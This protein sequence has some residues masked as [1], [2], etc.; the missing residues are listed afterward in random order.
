MFSKI[1]SLSQTSINK[2]N[3]LFPQIVISIL[4]ASKLKNQTEFSLE[5]IMGRYLNSK[6]KNSKFPQKLTSSLLL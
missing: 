2:K 5:E 4:A 6:F 3:Q 1:I